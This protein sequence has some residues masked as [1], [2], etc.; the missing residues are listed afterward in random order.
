MKKTRITFKGPGAK[1]KKYGVNTDVKSRENYFSDLNEVITNNPELINVEVLFKDIRGLENHNGKVEH[2]SSTHD[3]TLLSWLIFR[4]ATR[5]LTWRFFVRGLDSKSAEKDL[6][7]FVEYNKLT[8]EDI[9]EKT[10]KRR[11]L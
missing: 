3:D 11:L 4:Y 10:K 9:I 8:K 6:G 2:S 7:K 1:T 5:Q